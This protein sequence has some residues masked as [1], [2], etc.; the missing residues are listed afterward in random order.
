M[1]S[2]MEMVV[3]ELVIFRGKADRV[4]SRLNNDRDVFTAIRIDGEEG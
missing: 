2:E 1:E 3:V 4:L